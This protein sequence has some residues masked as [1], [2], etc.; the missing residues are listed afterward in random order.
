RTAFR[1]SPKNSLRT[2]LVLLEAKTLRTS[3]QIEAFS[4]LFQG[5]ADS[6]LSQGTYRFQHSELGSFD[7]F[8]VPRSQDKGGQYYEACFNRLVG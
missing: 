7:M 2:E 1:V 4:L 8:I 6:A 3:S 5:A